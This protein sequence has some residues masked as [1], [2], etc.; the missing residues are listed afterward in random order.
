MEEVLQPERI[1]TSE[2]RRPCSLFMLN[3]DGNVILKTILKAKV[4]ST[5]IKKVIFFK[6]LQTAT[7][8]VLTCRQVTTLRL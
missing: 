6:P 7:F 4:I 1:T 8:I 3:L 5:Q 2:L